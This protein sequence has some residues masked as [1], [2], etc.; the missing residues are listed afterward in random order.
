M[1]GVDYKNKWDLSP[2][3]IEAATQQEREAPPFST[4][5]VVFNS[6]PKRLRE[7]I[8]IVGG[9]S[10][11]KGESW[12]LHRLV[13]KMNT[14]MIS[15]L[16]LFYTWTIL[17]FPCSGGIPQSPA[18]LNGNSSKLASSSRDRQPRERTFLSTCRPCCSRRLPIFRS[19]PPPPGELARRCRLFKQLGSARK[20]AHECKATVRVV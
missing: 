6:I 11:Y 5:S 19:M 13:C 1:C 8:A 7:C 14:M 3:N 20:A 4:Y 18:K 10:H 16:D 17:I 2:R 15:L 12:V 9:T